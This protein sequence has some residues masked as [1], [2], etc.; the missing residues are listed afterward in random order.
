MD[1]FAQQFKLVL[2]RLRRAPLFTAITLITLAAGVGAN[3]VVF[4]VL[5]GVLLKPLPYPHAEQ[6][7]GVWHS[8][9]G[10]NVSPNSSPLPP[11]IS[12]IAIRTTP[13]KTS[14]CTPKIPSASPASP[15]PSK[16]ARSTSPMALSRFSAFH[17]ELG[18]WFSREDDSPGTPET[19]MLTYG[20]WHRKF[21]GSP[22]ILG[23]SI[24][25][26]GKSRTIIGVL[27]AAISF[28]RYGRSRRHS[29][30]QV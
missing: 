25:V 5:E 27:A 24:M 7:I 8:A 12:P 2:R 26:D 19:A 20:Y 11:T 14:A 22:G 18:R 10:L 15:S 21:G 16:S 28:P 29:S 1:S 9:P 3:T 4:S 13:F 6:L 23:Q 30:A 17:P